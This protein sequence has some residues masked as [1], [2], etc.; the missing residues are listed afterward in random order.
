M[1][2]DY[3]MLIFLV[4]ILLSGCILIPNSC[5]PPYITTQDGTCCL[6]ENGNKICD[7]EELGHL[8]LVVKEPEA[9]C[10]DGIQN[11]GEEGIDCGGP[12]KP[13]PSCEDGIQNQGEEGIDCGG[14]CKPCPSC[15]DGIQ[16]QGEE[17]I[18]LVVLVNHVKSLPHALTAFKTREKK[19]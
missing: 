19:A 5:A 17:G 16:N 13:C 18:D 3:V 2:S 1:R 12:C 10:S 8:M 14:P 11:Q 4:C 6:D 15:E 7:E 9:N